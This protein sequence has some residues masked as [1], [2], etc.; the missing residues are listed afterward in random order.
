MVQE[1]FDPFSSAGHADV[2]HRLRAARTGEAVSCPHA[3][4]YFVADDAGA[5]AVLADVEQFSNA[6][7]FELQRGPAPSLSDPIGLITR[8][9]P[10]RHTAL[11][12]FLR[13]W[14]APANLRAREAQVRTI[15]DEVIAG[16]P[17]TGLVDLAADVARIVPT[18][19]VYAFIGLPPA[20]W[21]TLQALADRSNALLPAKDPAI[22]GEFFGVLAGVLEER[23]ASG[24]RH[25]DIVDGLLYPGEDAPFEPDEATRHLYQLIAAGTDT[26]TGLITNLLYRL[27]EEPDRWKRIVDDPALI[28]RAIEESLR[29]DSPL[30]YTMR[31]AASDVRLGDF[32]VA[33][34]DRVL[35]GLQ[36]ANL[37][38][39][40]WGETAL[41]FDIDRAGATGHAA[42]APGI[43][44][45]L[46]APLARL[47]TRLT[48]EALA[49]HYPQLRLADDFMLEFQPIA[50][51]RALR[52]LRVTLGQPA[53]QA[54][55]ATMRLEVDRQRCEGHGLC[56]STAPD[57]VHLEEDG[58][59]VVDRPDVPEELATAA[60]Q[61]VRVCPVAALRLT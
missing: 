29:R 24:E 51:V 31:T 54:T 19:T 11:R 56:E 59:V 52:S 48:I 22:L 26:T 35:V 42:F 30:Q 23:R 39:Q 40:V 21:G 28:G 46:G 10:P 18:R 7:N 6:Y 60:A 43:H 13:R 2:E 47:E 33:P 57:L 1:S 34:R 8:S 12:Q 27:L 16:F 25:D 49:R 5:R 50:Q 44:S 61:A 17:A 37:D 20:T 38:E 32:D 36:S 4:V 55:A 53:G 9:D 41:D 15:V 3:G 58:I 14:F 45:C